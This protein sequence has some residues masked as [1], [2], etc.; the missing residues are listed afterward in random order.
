M[1]YKVIT[2]QRQVYQNGILDRETTGNSFKLTAVAKF[3]CIN[4]TEQ[5]IRLP[6]VYHVA[7]QNDNR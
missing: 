4:E 7:D 2:F 1:V 3:K 5:M 6:L